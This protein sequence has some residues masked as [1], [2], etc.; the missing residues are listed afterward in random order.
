MCPPL[1]EPKQ[2]IQTKRQMKSDIHIFLSLLS[3]LFYL[4]AH[5]IGPIYPS[6]TKKNKKSEYNPSKQYDDW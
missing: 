6:E 4:V 2:H 3:L 1:P 5:C